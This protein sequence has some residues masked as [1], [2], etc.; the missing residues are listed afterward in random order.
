VVLAAPNLSYSPY[1]HAVAGGWPGGCPGA[2]GRACTASESTGRPAPPAAPLPIERS[3][4]VRVLAGK[5]EANDLERQIMAP[6]VVQVV[7]VNQRPVEGAEVVFR[8]PVSGPGAT[9]AGGKT[10]QT[11][12]TNGGVKLP[13]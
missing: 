7:D 2:G 13:P 4:T 1:R 12:R 3:L 9:F 5:D 11:V 10:S 8:F 6:M